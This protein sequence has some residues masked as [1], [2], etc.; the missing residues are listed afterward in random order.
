M[1]T[2]YLTSRKR[3]DSTCQLN[4]F[5][6]RVLSACNVFF[7]FFLSISRPRIRVILRAGFT[8]DYYLRT[9]VRRENARLATYRHSGVVVVH[10]I[11]RKEKLAHEPRL[12]PDD[13]YGAVRR[14]DR[15]GFFM[16]KI[17]ARE[18]Y[19]DD[20]DDDVSSRHRYAR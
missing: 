17:I 2:K 15:A 20:N 14:S 1:G 16:A 3:S 5:T 9:F 10:E 6:R 7:F 11:L 18:T 8:T 13:S 19:D 12:A 4:C